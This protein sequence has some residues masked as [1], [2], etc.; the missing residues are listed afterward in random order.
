MEK[1]LGLKLDEEI[2]VHIVMLNDIVISGMTSLS[3]FQFLHL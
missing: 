2:D 1:F 3:E